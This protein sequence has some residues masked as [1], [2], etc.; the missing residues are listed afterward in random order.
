MYILRI[1]KN[2]MLVREEETTEHT[3]HQLGKGETAELIIVED[4]YLLFKGKKDD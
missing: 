4:G 3:Q 1:Y 2:N